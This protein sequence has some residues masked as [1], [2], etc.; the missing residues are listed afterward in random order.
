[1]TSQFRQL[2]PYSSYHEAKGQ[3]WGQ[4]MAAIT[5]GL[6]DFQEICRKSCEQLN[7]KPTKANEAKCGK[8]INVE[9]QKYLEISKAAFET[10]IKALQTAYIEEQFRI[11]NMDCSCVFSSPKLRKQSQVKP[12]SRRKNSDQKPKSAK[13]PTKKIL[14]LSKKFV[15]YMNKKHNI[16]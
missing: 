11:I 15:K 16:K 5:P 8:E 7:A 14:P 9:L 13:K 3:L 12:K 1:M 4:Y 6:K 2:T 10:Y